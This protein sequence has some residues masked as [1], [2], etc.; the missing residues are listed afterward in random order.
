MSCITQSLPLMLME[1]V[2]RSSEDPYTDD[3]Y[4]QESFISRL[5]TLGFKVW[6]LRYVAMIGIGIWDQWSLKQRCLALNGASLFF[7]Q[8]KRRTKTN[9]DS[10]CSS[11]HG[12][13]W[14]S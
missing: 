8:P 4:Y 3:H 12:R 1:K 2:G 6:I 13:R 14:P 10:L 7:I 11:C 5:V 9:Q